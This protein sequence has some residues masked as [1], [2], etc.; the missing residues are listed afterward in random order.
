MINTIKKYYNE[1]A[2]ISIYNDSDDT[3]KHFTGYIN[4]YNDC[5][6][7]V[8]HITPRGEYDGYILLH[9]DDIFRIEA[10]GKYE[11]KIEKLYSLKKQKHEKFTFDNDGIAYQL[12]D[13]ASE[14]N[15]IVRFEFHDDIRC[16]FIDKYDQ[17][18]CTINPVNDFGK[19]DG[20]ATIDINKAEIISVDTDF[21]Q[22]LKLIFESRI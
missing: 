3:T 17:S 1:N 22:D 4:S 18:I 2:V 14:N 13:F 5:E 6:I 16:G 12:L 9:I 19:S 20:T 10:N 11:E 21:E 7:L 15:L 8:S